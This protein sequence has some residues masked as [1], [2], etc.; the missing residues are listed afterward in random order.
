MLLLSFMMIS[1]FFGSK[2]S[3]RRLILYHLN[4]NICLIFMVFGVYLRLLFFFFAY[5]WVF[6]FQFGVI[7]YDNF[8]HWLYLLPL[9]CLSSRLRLMFLPLFFLFYLNNFNILMVWKI[10]FNPFLY[11]HLYIKGLAE[12]SVFGCE[13]ILDV[14]KPLTPS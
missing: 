2:M 12:I 7:G 4:F 3:C 1:L 8:L 13:I 11:F 5:I 14:R 9:M 6:L 10:F